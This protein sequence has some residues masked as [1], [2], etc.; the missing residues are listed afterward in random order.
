MAVSKL[1]NTTTMSIEVK[2]GEDKMGDPTFSKK[3][4]SNI[5][6]NAAPENIL[7]VAQAIKGI[8][9]EETKDVYLTESS[10]ISQ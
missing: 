8:L 4:F 6:N 2:S 3:T 10:V 9:S 7:E 1:L 5:K